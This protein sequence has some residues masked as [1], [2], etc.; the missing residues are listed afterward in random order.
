MPTGAADPSPPS[1]FVS[2]W[3][4]LARPWGDR[5]PSRKGEAGNVTAFVAVF[6]ASVLLVMGLVYDGGRLIAT[7]RRAANLA[8]GAARAAAQALDEGQRREGRT[9]LV[10]TRARTNAAQFL[11][12]CDCS[13][14]VGVNG[15]QATVTV[16]INYTPA[17]FPPA[18]SEVR[19]KGTADFEEG[20]TGP[21][22]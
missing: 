2:L 12:D 21:I 15:S 17:F 19:Q 3:S 20:V 5:T 22:P 1:G 4:R 8:D 16:T 14:T 18:A 7:Q 13:F 11:C 10:P 9:V 6:T